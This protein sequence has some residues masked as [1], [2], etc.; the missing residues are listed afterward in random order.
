MTLICAY[1][2]KRF[3]WT[4]SKA[5]E[6]LSFRRQ[7]IELRPSHIN[8]LKAQVERLKDKNPTNSWGE[9][10]LTD[11]EEC[12]MRNTYNNAQMTS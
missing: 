11:I 10:D 3:N 8:Q 7:G 5:L 1:L 2:I 6:F 9:C 4:L 12:I